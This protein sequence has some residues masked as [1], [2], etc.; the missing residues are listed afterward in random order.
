[1]AWM[2][3]VEKR[4]RRNSVGANLVGQEQRGREWLYR[5][6]DTVM[7]AALSLSHRVWLR[8]L[9]IYVGFALTRA[10]ARGIPFQ[11]WS[12]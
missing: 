12:L 10:M 11:V 5:A 3:L 4:S 8:A 9:A 2:R 6:D 1:M 7:N